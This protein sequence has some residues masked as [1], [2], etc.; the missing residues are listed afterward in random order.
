MPASMT[1]DQAGLSAG[2]PGKAREDGLDDGSLVTLTSN[3]HVSTFQFSLLWVGQHPTPDVDSESTLDHPAGQDHAT[4]QPTA[5]VYGSW[6]IRLVTDEGTPFEDEQIRI[7]AIKE[8][9]SAIR[10]PA[11]NERSDPEATLLNNGASIVAA[12]EFNA[13]DGVTDSPQEADTFVSYWKA[14]ADL[15]YAHNNAAPGGSGQNNAFVYDSGG[16]QSGNVYTSAADLMAAVVAVPGIKIVYLETDFAM[17]AGNYDL[18]G[19]RW[20]SKFGQGR[21]ITAGDGVTFDGDL[22]L[23]QNVTLES[24]SS[25]PL[26]EVGTSAAYYRMGVT[27]ESYAYLYHNGAADG[28]ISIGDGEVYVQVNGYGEM[29]GPCFYFQSAAAGHLELETTY[30][31]GEDVVAG[32]FV[33]N[34]VY[35]AHRGIRP[36]G[37][38][39]SQQDQF[40]PAFYHRMP[41]VPMQ[42]RYTFLLNTVS[43][44]KPDYWREAENVYLDSGGVVRAITGF[45][46]AT[47]AYDAGNPYSTPVKY[48]YNI[49]TGGIQ[50]QHE[51]ASEIV[52]ANRVITS[53][54]ASLTIPARGCARLVYDDVALRWRMHLL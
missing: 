12:S 45:D 40:S 13:G 18:T 20:E 42:A 49:G 30:P 34:Q 22:H 26:W 33:A 41:V 2:A 23:G 3:D 48:L 10:I 31:P 7:F 21:T 8:S 25:S 11:A 5:G 53:T 51:S 4:F 15:I 47:D 17:P 9:P 46:A 29:A 44:L 54:G 14:I 28:M 38:W 36:A 6:R 52:L 43:A 50:V 32:T 27:L 37:D 24:N 16:I 35:A 1:I 19:I 39:V